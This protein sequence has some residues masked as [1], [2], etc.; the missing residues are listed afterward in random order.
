MCAC[1]YARVCV[2]VCACMSVYLCTC[3]CMCMCM[4]VCMH[5]W[6]YVCVGVSVYVRVRMHARV[7]VCLCGSECVC[8]CAYE[9][10]R[11]H[12]QTF[13]KPFKHIADWAVLISADRNM[14][15]Q[16]NTPQNDVSVHNR[17]QSMVDITDM[18]ATLD[19]HRQ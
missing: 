13:S 1:M 19:G 7:G 3:V 5:V 17:I 9:H 8:V 12:V 16:F 6:E 15:K 2:S 14:Q 11:K 10:I 18:P 4:Y